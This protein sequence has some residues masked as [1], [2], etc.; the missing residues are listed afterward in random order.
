MKK[1]VENGIIMSPR[2]Y[3]AMAIIAMAHGHS[4]NFCIGIN[5]PY[6]LV[7][8]IHRQ[9]NAGTDFIKMVVSHD[10]LFHIKQEH[11]LPWCTQEYLVLAAETAHELYT[12]LAAHATGTESVRRVL[13][14]KFDCIEHGIGLTPEMASQMKEQETFYVPT[15]TGYLENAREK[16]NRGPGW[17]EHYQK[18]WAWHQSTFVNAIQAKVQLVAG[19]DT[20]GDLN[21]EIA[22][23]HK[24]GLT[25]HEALETAT[26]NAARL[27]DMEDR[28]GSLAKGKL[29]DFV[30]LKDNPLNDLAALYTVDAVCLNGH[31]MS[32]QAID[33]VIPGSR[34]YIE[35]W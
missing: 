35:N 3:C 15:L 24:F 6:E 21:E 19:T 25:K 33:A 2:M 30:V 5:S 23:M 11:S 32:V 28:I 29:A 17:A 10:D 9:I 12:K 4:S 31:L 7:S 8:E 34:F 26:I 20:L 18:I 13:N 16:W 1:A 22:L 14:A 27:M